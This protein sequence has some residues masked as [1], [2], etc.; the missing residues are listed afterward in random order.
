[1]ITPDDVR[2]LA[3][4]LPETTQGTHFRNIAFKVR[5]RSF[6]G[7]EG[8]THVTLSLGE[9]EVRAAVADETGIE[10]IRRSDRPIGIRV[11]LGAIAPDRF[12]R[13]IELSW[14][15]A[16]PKRLVTEYEHR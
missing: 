10:E 11:D 12:A 7:L 5:G 6:A 15:H 14:R 4:A 1:M 3:L 8:D 13:L 9:E 2:R 16:A